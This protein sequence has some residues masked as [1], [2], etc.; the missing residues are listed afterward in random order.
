MRNLIRVMLNLN[1]DLRPN[2]K[3]VIS[4]LKGMNEVIGKSPKMITANG[5]ITPISL[6]KPMKNAKTVNTSRVKETLDFIFFHLP[7]ISVSCCSLHIDCLPV[8]VL[9][10][11]GYIDTYCHDK[12]QSHTNF[13]VF[14][15][16][17]NHTY[18]WI[19]SSSHVSILINMLIITILVM[20]NA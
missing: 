14:K 8:Y 15:T 13:Y 16:N 19:S 11:P 2:I 20:Q 3:N 9:L 18:L 6:N 5:V 12:C 7:I 17:S 4:I 10:S 1:P